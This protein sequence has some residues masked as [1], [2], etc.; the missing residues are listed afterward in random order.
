MYTGRGPIGDEKD[1][2]NASMSALIS[3]AGELSKIGSDVDCV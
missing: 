3:S 1:E 2:R